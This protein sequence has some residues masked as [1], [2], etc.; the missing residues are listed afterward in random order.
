MKVFVAGASGAMGQRLVPRLVAAG[1]EVAALT[2]DESRA[3]RI[4]EMGAQA[5]IGDALDRDSVVTAVRQSEPEVLIHQ[6]TGLAGARNFRNFDKVFA[7]TNRLRTE[8][9]D[10]LIEGALAAGTRRI[11]AQ[12]YGNWNYARTGTEPKTEEDPLDPTPPAHQVKSLEAIRYVEQAVLNAPALDGMA[13]RY[14]GFYGPGTSVDL[15]GEITEQ[16][17]KGRFPI[18]GDGAGVWSLVHIDDAVSATIAAVEHGSPGIYNIADDEPA[19]IAEWLPELARVLGAK[20]PRHVPVW[21]GRL[22]AGEVGVSMMTQIR[23]ASN[24]KAKAQ[25]GWAP[26]YPSYR[27][28]FRAGLSEVPIPGVGPDRVRG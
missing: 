17:R 7:L 5:V 24:A 6:L 4:R 26:R 10:Y 21:L 8:A 20:P 28:G 16:V 12:S 27:E 18:V 23:G 1:H 11:V 19:P 25:L 3:A 13:L 9:T 15:G 14:G 22:A 2:R